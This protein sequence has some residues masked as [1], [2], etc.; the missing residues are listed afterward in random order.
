MTSRDDVDRWTYEASTEYGH[1]VSANRMAEM[2]HM[3][4]EAAALLTAWYEVG[5][6]IE[7][8]VSVSLPTREWL[9]EWREEAADD[10]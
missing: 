3:L 8:G 10:A 9:T 1:Y 5:G 7:D 6:D 4:A 2:L